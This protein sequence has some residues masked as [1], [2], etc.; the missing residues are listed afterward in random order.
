MSEGID[1]ITRLKITQAHEFL[2]GFFKM[3]V[4]YEI[5]KRR[6]LGYTITRTSNKQIHLSVFVGLCEAAMTLLGNP[7]A[8]D[9]N[10][11]HGY[12]S[13]MGTLERDRKFFDRPLQEVLDEAEERAQHPAKE[14]ARQRKARGRTAFEAYCAAQDGKTYDN[15]DIP[16]WDVLPSNI[17]EAWAAAAQAVLEAL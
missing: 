15:K 13:L 3:G 12:G 16:G 2:N 6:L 11:G 5:P 1:P 7:D 4:D 9:V 17:Q 8:K 10:K 14:R